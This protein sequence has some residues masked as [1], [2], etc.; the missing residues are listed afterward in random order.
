MARRGLLLGKPRS[1][2]FPLLNGPDDSAPPSDLSWNR[3]AASF[4]VRN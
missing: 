2:F 1:G 3:L 4:V